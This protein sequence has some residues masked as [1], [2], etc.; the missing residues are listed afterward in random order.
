KVDGPRVGF[1]LVAQVGPLRFYWRVVAPYRSD[2]RLSLRLLRDEFAGYDLK[3][4]LI[5]EPI[6]CPTGTDTPLP[7][8]R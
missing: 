5:S 6:H 3:Y 1:V 2:F 8:I 7:I 4:R